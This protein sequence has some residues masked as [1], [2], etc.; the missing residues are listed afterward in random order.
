[1]GILEAYDLAGTLRGAAA[2]AGCDHKTVAHWVRV[3]E[4]A[5]GMPVA[6]RRR[7]AVGEFAAKIDELVERSGGR[8]RADVAHAKL[9]ALGYEGSPRTTRRWVAE[10][11]RRWRREH[12][13]RTRPL[14]YDDP[15]LNRIMPWAGTKHGARAFVDNFKGVRK[16]WTNDSFE[17]T[18]TIEQDGKVAVFGRFTLTSVTLRQSSDSAFVVFA[19][20]ADERITYFQY[21]E[22]TFATART[23]REGGTWT[24]RADPSASD[25]IHV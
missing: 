3:R 22:D 8:I 25:P 1:M 12:G 19:K 13:R 15:E 16:H 18:E 24:I 7:P 10:S 20:V 17:I 5:G 6:G 23:F 2:L 11:K 14:N 9:I 4:L 21:M